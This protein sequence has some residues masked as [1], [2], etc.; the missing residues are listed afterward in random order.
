MIENN[1]KIHNIE[2]NQQERIESLV[3]N[4]NYKYW[5]GGFIEGEG[6]LTISIVKNNKLRWGFALQPEFNVTQHISGLHVLYS[7]KHLFDNLGS[8]HK[9]SGS[10]NVWVYVLKGIYNV[11][12]HALPFYEE[13]VTPF[14]SKYKYEQLENVKYIVNILHNN[15]RQS[16]DKD[17]FI[18][19]LKLTYELN[20]EGKG[21]NRLRSLE[22]V[23]NTV[24]SLK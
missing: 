21:K 5:L 2:T 12:T 20:P 8:V 7:F 18:K 22:D 10:E 13:Y 11:K 14:S 17:L 23:I 24:N 4:N 19:L 1:V 3:K 15:A 16:M 6:S 9:K